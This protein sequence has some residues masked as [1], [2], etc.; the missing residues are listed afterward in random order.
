MADVLLIHKL[1]PANL[2]NRANFPG[3]K[4]DE[5]DYCLIPSARERDALSDSVSVAH[6]NCCVREVREETGLVIDADKFAFV[7]SLRFMFA[8][9][10]AECR[11]YCSD[12]DIA[13]A[14]SLT[15]EKIFCA[16]VIS[17]LEGSAL[18][19]DGEV[20]QP[21]GNLAWLCAMARQTI[22]HVNESTYIVSA[23][24]DHA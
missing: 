4:V 18:C 14:S 11:F 3:G 15:D 5:I 23:I 12:A 19:C 2:M 9:E 20:L 13:Q 24:D 16:S 8:G 10:E 17:V 1:K 22:R 21:M 6:I 7:C